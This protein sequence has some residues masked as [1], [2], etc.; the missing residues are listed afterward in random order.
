MD[1]DAHLDRPPTFD[2]FPNLRKLTGS[3]LENWPQHQD[4][5]SL[6]FNDSDDESFHMSE[7]MAGLVLALAGSR[8]SDFCDDYKWMCD[9][10]MREEINF[11]ST[12]KYR[13]STFQDAYDQVYSK[14]EYMSRY[15]NGIL[16]SQVLWRNQ[17]VAMLYY[18]QNFLGGADGGDHLEVGPGHGMLLHFAE[19]CGKFRSLTGWDVSESSFKATQHALSVWGTG[20]ATTLKIQ[21]IMEPVDRDQKFDSVVISE[22][23]EHLDH[24]D[25]A[26]LNLANCMRPGG[27]IFVNVPVNSPA[28]DHIFL[29]STPEKVVELVASC[30]FEISD[31]ALAPVTGH[32]VDSARKR[33][34]TLNALITGIRN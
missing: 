15:I 25:V 19:K 26:L 17:A 16:L 12:G 9:N 1:K 4:Y 23:L 33:K 13:L 8:V 24:P 11:R 21:N 28:P 20:S 34:L 30:G 18:I 22:V 31:S 3:V 5:I 7:Q 32:T 6:R 27:R 29:W 14:P 10:F 2:N